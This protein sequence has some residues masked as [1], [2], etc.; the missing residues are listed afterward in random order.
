MG[1]VG[2]TLFGVSVVDPSHGQR[3]PWSFSSA[4]G[5]LSKV[6][7]PGRTRRQGKP[8]LPKAAASR[9]ASLKAPALRCRGQL[10]SSATSSGKNRHPQKWT[11]KGRRHHIPRP[12]ACPHQTAIASM[13]RGR[14][15]SFGEGPGETGHWPPFASFRTDMEK[16]VSEITC[17]DRPNNDGKAPYN[18]PNDWLR[19]MPRA[20][21]LVHRSPLTVLTAGTLRM[22]PVEA[23]Y[24]HRR[25]QGKGNGGMLDAKRKSTSPTASGRPPRMTRPLLR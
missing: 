21:I 22:G 9:F 15:I 14:L 5:N 24:S 6:S 18:S 19:P 20:A 25:A 10:Y 11:P 2:L 13:P 8:R 17:V 7:P 4:P 12:I 3:L 16:R 23:V 1:E